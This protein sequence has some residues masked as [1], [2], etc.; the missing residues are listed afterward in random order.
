MPS[1]HKPTTP[2][3]RPTARAV[4]A[5]WRR[6]LVAAMALAAGIFIGALSF[7]TVWAATHPELAFQI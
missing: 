3:H 6:D 4:V 5:P 1:V 7:A 2:S